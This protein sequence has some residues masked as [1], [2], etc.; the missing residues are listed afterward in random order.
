MILVHPLLGKRARLDVA[1]NLLHGG[2]CVIRNDL[3]AAHVVAPLGGVAHAVAHVGKAALV[4]EVHNQL[5][6]VQTLEIGNF[7]L[8]AR[9]DQRIERRLDQFA[10]AAAEHGLLA[11]EVSLGLLCEGRLEDTRACGADALGVGECVGQRVARGVLLHSHERGHARAFLEYLAH[12]VA[13]GLG[14]DHRHINMGGRHNLAEANVEAV[15]EHDRVARLEVGLDFVMIDLPLDGVG[16]QDHDHVGLGSRVGHAEDAQA[17]RFGLGLAPGAFMQ[18][19][20]H[21]GAG[22]AQVERVGVALA[23][24]ADDGN[25]LA[26]EQR[27]VGLVFVIDLRHEFSSLDSVVGF[28]TQVII[29]D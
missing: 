5:E 14:R 10:H 23:A 4:D 29:D 2:A 18:A 28:S 11:K 16:Q 3:G 22:V 6:F 21:V 20:A 15:G 25:L 9:L 17:I 7:G 13:G 19:H 26:V 8:V 1:Q 12:T 27:Q 24:V